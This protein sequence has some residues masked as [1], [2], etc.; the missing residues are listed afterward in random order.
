[1]I[2]RIDYI[3]HTHNTSNLIFLRYTKITF[4]Y[5][6]KRTKAPLRISWY[7]LDTDLFVRSAISFNA[8]S[9]SCDLYWYHNFIFFHLIC[10]N[11][12]QNILAVFGSKF[13][14]LLTI[15]L[16]LTIDLSSFYDFLFANE[17]YK[18]ALMLWSILIL[19]KTKYSSFEFPTFSR[20]SIFFL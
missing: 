3:H 11:L 1:M 10:M 4:S 15:N 6:A 9:V 17:R 5:V 7:F 20:T 14:L 18:T 16:F 19:F 12:M 8:S 2:W 13:V